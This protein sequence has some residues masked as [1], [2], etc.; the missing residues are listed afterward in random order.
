MIRGCWC[1]MQ[2]ANDV[3]TFNRHNLKNLIKAVLMQIIAS[4]FFV[5]D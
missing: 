1:V 5:T 4:I 3:A 2:P